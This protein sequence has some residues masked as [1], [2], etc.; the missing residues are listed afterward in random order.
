MLQH[1]KNASYKRIKVYYTFKIT[2][3]EHRQ[4]KS[5]IKEHK[6][7]CKKRYKINFKINTNVIIALALAIILIILIILFTKMFL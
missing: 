3:E 5:F 2:S 6:L 7:P 1:E 4:L